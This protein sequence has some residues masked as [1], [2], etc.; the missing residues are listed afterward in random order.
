MLVSFARV[1]PRHSHTIGVNTLRV[2]APALP[3]Q[4]RMV[5]PALAS[6]PQHRAYSAA[7]AKS[8][9]VHVDQ[10]LKKFYKKVHPDLFTAEPEKRVQTYL[11]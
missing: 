8:E 7:T 3:V 11:R 4:T 5:R 10:V 6:A 2:R 1:L 9:P